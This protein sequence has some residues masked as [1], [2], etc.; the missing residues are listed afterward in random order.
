MV[1]IDLQNML[2][3][4]NA[5]ELRM[6]LVRRV[7]SKID[8]GPVYTVDPQRRSAYAGEPKRDPVVS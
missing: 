4:Q 6:G 2:G 8:I 1:E 3:L 7:P 5:D